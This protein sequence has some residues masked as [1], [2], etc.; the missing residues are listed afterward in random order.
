MEVIVHKILIA[1]CCLFLGCCSAG[2]DWRSL[3]HKGFDLTLQGQFQE[4]SLEF[5]RAVNLMSEEE[6]NLYP[7]VLISRADANS[8]LGDYSKVIQDTGIALKSKNLTDYER[9]ICAMKRNA[10]FFFLGDDN[11]SADTCE[12]YLQDSP[13]LS[14]RDYFKDKVIIRNIPDCQFYKEMEK[15]RLREKYCEKDEDISDYGS[16]WIVNITK[17]SSD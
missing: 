3:W 11:H 12:K 10:A 9:L 7:Y 14:K 2:N 13:L 17:Q 1:F 16:M 4:A 15:K 6:L 5:D 8:L